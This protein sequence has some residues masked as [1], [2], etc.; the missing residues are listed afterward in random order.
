MYLFCGWRGQLYALKGMETGKVRQ[1]PWR[2][3]PTLINIVAMFESMDSFQ[4]PRT[5]DFC[6]FWIDIF[7][8]DVM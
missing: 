3:Q 1:V 2:S 4:P 6:L 5:K 7:N 8:V